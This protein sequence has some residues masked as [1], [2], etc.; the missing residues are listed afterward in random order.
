MAAELPRPGVEVIQVFRTTSPTIVTPTLVPVVVGVCKQIV[1]LLVASSGGGSQLNTDALIL[2][3]GMFKTQPA[4]GSPPAFTGLNGLNLVLSINNGPDVTVTFDDPSLTG[5]TPAALAQQINTQFATLLVTEAQAGYTDNNE[6]YIRTIG[7]GEF[8]SLEIRPGSDPIVLSAFGGVNNGWVIGYVL[9]GASYYSQYE[10]GV[11]I[12]S[13]PDPRGNL[14]ELAI[15]PSTVR[16]FTSTG[17]SQAGFREYLKD[18][19]YLRKGGGGSAAALVGTVDLSTLTYGPAGTLDG[20]DLGVSLDGGTAVAVDF[21]TGLTTVADEEDLIQRIN[22]TLGG[23]YASLSGA[24]LRIASD[25]TG[26]DS[27]VTLTDVAGTPT[28]SLGFASPNNTNTGAAGVQVIDDGNGD[29]LSPLLKFIGE[30]FTAAGTPAVFTPLGVDYSNAGMLASLA[31]LTI[32]MSINGSR[33]QTLTFGVL[34]TANDLKAAVEGYFPNLTLDVTAPAA[35]FWQA[36][37]AGEESTVWFVGG[38]AL[39]ALGIVPML[40][41]DWNTSQIRTPGTA[42]TDYTYLVG[43]NFR[44]NLGGTVVEHTWT[45]AVVD[46]ATMLADL[47]ANVAFAALAIAE[48]GTVA[49][50]VRIKLLTGADGAIVSVVAATANESAPLLGYSPGDYNTLGPA[51]GTGYL[52]ISGDELYVD[53]ELIARITQVAPGG[54]VDVLK[55]AVQL[56]LSDEYGVYWYIWAKN[57]PDTN[58]PTPD[59]TVDS[60]GNVVMKHQTVRDS[61]GN[62]VSMNSVKTPIYIAYRA[63]RQDVTSIADNPGLLRFDTTLQLDDALSPVSTANPLALGVY[64]A[65]LNAPGAQVTALGVDEISADAPYGTVDGFTRACEFLEAYEVYAMAPLT[66]DETVAQVFNT[67]VT[68]MSV[69]ENKGERI[70]LFNFE[71]PSRK[72]DTLVASG[73]DGNSVGATG[74]VFDTGVVNL[75]SLLVAAG[76][77]PAGTIPVS[78]GLFLDIASDS[79]R[80]SIQ[81]V[82]GSQV[83]IRTVFAPGE[84]DDNFYSTTK[85]NVPPLPSALINEAFAVRVRGGE[86]VSSTG[87]IDKQGIAETYQKMAQAYLNR[88]FWSTVPARAKASLDGLEQVVEGFYMCAAIAGMIAQQAPH[89]SFTNFPMTGFTGVIGSSDFFS[90]RQLNIIA[91]G[92]NYI[93]VQDSAGSPLIARHALTTDM[94]SVETRTDSINKIV[95]FTA[96]F[97]RIGLKNYIGRFNITQGFLDSLSHVTQGLLG[98][99]TD[100]GVLVGANLNNIVQ[101]ED[102]PDTVLIDV[103]IDVPY[104]CNYIR[105]T[106]VI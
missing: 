23:M 35:P 101:D 30:D 50:S 67:H 57:L 106:L 41:S 25:S 38:T 4:V 64:F 73:T 75:T 55:V 98:F 82:S 10:Q 74:T 32:T 88:R 62:L 39:G 78:D 99:L 29:N 45:G 36:G 12:I 2:L 5:I 65:L 85:L 34:A 3:P 83:T 31:G 1:D 13:F 17:G 37:G 28:T 8:Q 60:Y 77:N 33:P 20:A 95:D 71:T 46:F 90:N 11:E 56:A 54:V 91:A 102:N 76:I 22:E 97:L 69:P 6:V 92:G 52:P 94:T 15:E 19:S 105:L 68:F 70:C 21:G 59:L 100:I 9:Y 43:K 16:V 87:T 24:Y 66:H 26:P 80:Y 81:S 48:A 79:K 42:G 103:T 72:V 58:R 51:F 96:K 40:T 44:L 84:N 86:L 61:N 27:V 7:T 63:V 53:G 14:S 89:Q 104:P 47:N 93:I 18:Q 49:N